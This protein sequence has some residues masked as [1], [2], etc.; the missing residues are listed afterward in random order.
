MTN[1]GIDLVI[2]QSIQQYYDSPLDS[3]LKYHLSHPIETYFSITL[4]RTDMNI[5]ALLQ[6]VTPSQDSHSDGY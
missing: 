5:A 1:I 3:N 2:P 6:Y 4:K